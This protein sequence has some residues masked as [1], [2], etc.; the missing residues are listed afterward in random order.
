MGL[1]DFFEDIAN[2]VCSIGNVVGN[3]VGTA[4]EKL[5]DALSLGFVSDVGFNIQL[6]CNF[7]EIRWVP[8]SSGDKTA[9]AHN[10]LDQVKMQIAPQ[11]EA[12]EARLTQ[13]CISQIAELID[14]FESVFSNETV[15]YLKRQYRQEITDSLSG[16]FMGYIQPRLSFVDERCK[17]ILDEPDSTRSHSAQEYQNALLKEAEEAFLGK[18]K[19]LYL[20]YVNHIRSKVQTELGHL[21][22][23]YIEKSKLLERIMEETC[24]EENIDL[25]RASVLSL[26]AKLITISDLTTI[27]H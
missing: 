8:N 15:D 23:V 19:Q 27:I 9:E 6:A 18:C 24:D 11:A 21:Q 26:Q 12:A 22:K 25:E 4:V 16:G 2:A 5:G 17:A 10:L 7:G 13:N 20:E 3:A 1:F 14:L